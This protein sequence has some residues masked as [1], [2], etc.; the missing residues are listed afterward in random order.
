V[1]L[2]RPPK[3]KELIKGFREFKP[4][5]FEENE[6]NEGFDCLIK[7]KLIKLGS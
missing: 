4:D 2:Q 3:K 6:I 5:R 1:S 7:A